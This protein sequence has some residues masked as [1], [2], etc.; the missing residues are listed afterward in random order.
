ML[1]SMGWIFIIISLIFMIVKGKPAFLI[2]ALFGVGLIWLQLRGKRIIVD[3]GER[4]IKA[5]GKTHKIKNPK[6]IYLKE[7]KMSQTVNARVSS[8]NVKT[9]FYKAY[10]LDGED[11]ILLSS[12]RKEERD[13]AKLKAIADELRVELEKKLLTV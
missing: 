10:L 12:N 5:G 6:K 4:I 11:K 8:S 1:N 3:T 7:V 13:M 2:V 9:Y